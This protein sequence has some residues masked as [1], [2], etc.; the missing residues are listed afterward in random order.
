MI[1][2]TMQKQPDPT[3]I[4]AQRKPNDTGAISVEGFIKIY[5]P[6]NKEVFVEQRA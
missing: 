2:N 1:D 3:I 5:D 4:P 6:A